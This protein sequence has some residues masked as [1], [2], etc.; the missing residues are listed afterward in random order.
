MDRF[1]ALVGASAA[2]SAAIVGKTF[3]AHLLALLAVP[4][5]VAFL[6]CLS[7][8]RSIAANARALAAYDDFFERAMR[9]YYGGQ[10]GVP[11]PWELRSLMPTKIRIGPFTSSDFEVLVLYFVLVLFPIFFALLALETKSASGNANAYLLASLFALL[12]AGMTLF[13]C[14]RLYRAKRYRLLIKS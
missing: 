7:I 3:E 11:N 8:A 12:S 6:L 10:S 14:F 9:Y 2:F 1:M 5:F 13:A 4:L